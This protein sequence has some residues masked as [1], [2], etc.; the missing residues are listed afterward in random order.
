MVALRLISV[1]VAAGLIAQAIGGT[2]AS[3]V[4]G[5]SAGSAM[6][7]GTFMATREA[8][9]VTLV[10]GGAAALGA[11]ASGQPW[12]GGAA[13]SLMVLVTAPATAYSAGILM[14]APL[15]TMLFA[16]AD[17]GWPWWLA[18]LWGVGGGLVGL[19][20][21][22]LM[23]FGKQPPSPLPWGLAWR[24]AIVLAI[25]A[26]VSVIVAEQLALDHGYW[27]AV[28]LLVALRPV[29][30]ERMAY[31]V[32]RIWGTLA[33]AAIA[34]I[35]VWLLPS[36]WLMLAAFAYLVALAA[37]AMSGEY[38]MQTMFLTPM[39]MIFLSSGDNTQATV[40]LTLGR[41]YYTII[42]AVLA[43]ALAWAMAAWDRRAGLADDRGTDP[44]AQGGSVA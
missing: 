25:A 27:V 22:A 31:A 4:V 10:L 17:R 42:G 21:A 26:G 24:H 12:L 41:V 40:E 20:I 13:V 8:T 2:T 1:V 39:L 38:F 23:R 19:A 15:L 14:L 9:A 32:Q 44:T 33:G 5:L 18:G 7:F 16:V 29:P 36:G 3:L 28:T 37:Y 30:E 6:T 11:G 35:T 34:L 43:A